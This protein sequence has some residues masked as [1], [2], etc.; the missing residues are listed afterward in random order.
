[1]K[2]SAKGKILMALHLSSNWLVNYNA[3]IVLLTP[4]MCLGER[5]KLLVDGVISLF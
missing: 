4:H 3:T 2:S 5:Q 1:M